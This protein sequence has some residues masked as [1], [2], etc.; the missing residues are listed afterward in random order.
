MPALEAAL[1]VNTAAGR[2]RGGRVAHAV[3]A[4]L[5]A[6][7][8]TPRVLTAADRSGAER[9]VRAAVSAGVALVAAVG[10][11][12]VAHAALQA[13]AGTRTPL[14]LVPAGSGND[15]AAELGVP[16]DPVAA[17]RAAADDLRTRQVRRVDLGRSG[18]RWWGTVLCCGFDA[19][20]TARAERLR[21]PRGPRR[22]DAAVLVELA[23][24]RPRAVTIT[25][26]GV[27]RDRQVT[28]V[29]VGNTARYG[30]GMR[31]CPGARPD[32]GELTVTVIGP[33]SRLGLVRAKPRLTDGSHLDHPAV[34]VL[35]GREVSLSGPGLTGWADGEPIGS[36]PLTAVVVPGALRIVGTR[37]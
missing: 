9:Q 7:G 27:R 21:W 29:A 22:Y 15:L 12:G 10:G 23:R 32:D 8:V 4:T 35:R 20:V 24:L 19:A 14:A 5:A 28:L 30:G 33:V 2:G 36:L 17:A 26:D 13:V 11:D 6:A 37:P 1:L 31:I 18:D 16:L 3:A 25:V 34:E